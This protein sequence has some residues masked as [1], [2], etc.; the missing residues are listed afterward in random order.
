MLIH[1]EIEAKLE[2]GDYIRE[3]SRLQEDVGEW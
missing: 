2:P 1:N 3:Y